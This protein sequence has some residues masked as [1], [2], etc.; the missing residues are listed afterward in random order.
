MK[1]H[2]NHQAPFWKLA[3]GGIAA[4][5]ALYFFPVLVPALAFVLLAGLILRGLF[6]G[7]RMHMRHAFAAHWQS[8]SEEQRM[9]M[10]ARYAAD[11]CG[12]WYKMPEEK[13]DT[14]N[15]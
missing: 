1:H 8:M 9:A 5:A 15:A 13:N 2:M 4:G 10:R 11:G 14:N 3:L 7:P 12:P 6:A